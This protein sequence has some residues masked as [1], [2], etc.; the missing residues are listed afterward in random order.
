MSIFLQ[1][2]GSDHPLVGTSYNNMGQ[3]YLNKGD[4]KKALAY[5]L[6]A[7]AIC[8]KKL[9]AQHPNTKIAQAWIDQ[10]NNE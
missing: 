5:F 7:K 1:A 2:L 10:I 8:L 3:S 4:K 9:G 6:K